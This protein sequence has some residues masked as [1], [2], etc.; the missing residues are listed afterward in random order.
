MMFLG[1]YASSNMTIILV[2]IYLR[3]VTMHWLGVD[4]D[5][6][7]GAMTF[8]AQM[9]CVMIMSVVSAMGRRKK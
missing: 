3:N 5:W 6:A 7:A 2:Y 8:S 4:N 9:S 1:M